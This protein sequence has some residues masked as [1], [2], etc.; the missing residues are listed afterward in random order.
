MFKIICVVA[1]YYF[2][3]WMGAFFGLILGAI[4]DRIRAFGQGAMNPLRNAIRQA[5]FLETVFIAMGKLAKADGRVS[6]EEMAHAEL[7]M[8]KLGMTEEHRKQAIVLFKKGAEPEFDIEPTLQ[9][10]MSVCGHTR[11]LKEMLLVY[12][13]VMALADGHVHE[14]E[15]ELLYDIAGRLGYGREAFKHLMDM[16]LNQTHFAGGKVT[17]AESLDDAYKALGVTK[18]SSDAEIKRAYRKLMSQYHP[19]KL[20]GQGLPEDMIKMATEQAKD[21]QLAY[22]LLKKHRNL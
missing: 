20:M 8:Q 11:N 4:I 1:G 10:F 13:V 14:A 5:V 15:Q 7:L 6:E 9:K 2:F 22:D 19:D 3:G 12:L 16:V 18:E 21:I 17:T